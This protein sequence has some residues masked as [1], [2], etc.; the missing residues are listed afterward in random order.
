[1]E[2]L[3]YRHLYRVDQAF[4]GNF[5]L[6]SAS[7]SFYREDDFASNGLRGLADFATALLKC[8]ES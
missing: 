4:L 8:I 1:M 5:K 7:G 2:E 3:S 6:K